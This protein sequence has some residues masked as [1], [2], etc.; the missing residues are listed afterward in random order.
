VHFVNFF[1]GPQNLSVLFNSLLIGFVVTLLCL[2]IGYPVAYFLSKKRS[3]ALLTLLFV[4]PMWINFLVRTL[5][6]KSLL[7]TIGIELGLG[8]L[9][10][11]LVYNFLPFMIMPLST[12]LSGIDKSYIEAAQDLGADNFTVFTKTVIP[13]SL[14][15]VISGV[16]MVFIPTISTFAISQ[17]LSG[18]ATIV[19]FG[20]AIYTYINTVNGYG[21]ASVMSLVMLAFVLISNFFMNKFNATQ[22]EAKSLW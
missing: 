22:T 7:E 11:G 19:L 1:T 21:V 18:S 20:D 8:T 15:G 6:T 9:I 3:G 2:I 10:I 17:Y 14:P 13:L 5:A 12:T 4:L 16:T